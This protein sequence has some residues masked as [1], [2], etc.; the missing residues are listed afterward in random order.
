[1][2]ENFILADGRWSGPH[3]I[4]RFSTEILARLNNTVVISDGPKPLSLKNIFWLG[5]KIKFYPNSR[6]YFSP[7]FNPVLFSPIPF[8]ITIHDLIHLRVNENFSFFKKIFYELF[9]KPTAKRAYKIFTVSDF[10]KRTILEWLKI[11]E[12]K[13]VV[14]YNG[15][16]DIFTAEGPRYS[17]GF[18][19]LL[20]VANNK[21][22]KNIE[23]LLIA[24]ANAKINHEIKLILTAKKTS[25]FD[26]IIK[27]YALSDR[28]VFLNNL[29]ETELAG[30][31]RGAL[32]LTFPSLYE[33][34]GLPILEAMASGVPVLTSNT[35]S[36]PEVAGDAAILVDPYDT[37]AI[38]RGV[39]KIVNNLPLRDE[40]HRNGLERAKFFTWEK[41]ASKIEEILSESP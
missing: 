16:S 26:A 27:K 31:Y 35:T 9:I 2:T 17:P 20:N 32:A 22:H 12:E 28:I 3:G 39:E 25:E 5:P 10:S 4:G 23:R 21:P 37:D 24:F 6:I 29:S 14:V 33:G 7:G 11:P 36:M 18:S 1:M 19:Y 41:T 38:A 13:V 34:F 30:L 40:L 15:I 8:T